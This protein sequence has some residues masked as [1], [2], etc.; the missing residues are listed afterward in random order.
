MPLFVEPF[1]KLD[2]LLGEAPPRFLIDR[3]SGLVRLLVTLVRLFPKLAGSI[4][5]INRNA[6]K[7]VWLLNVAT[8][9]RYMD[10][11]SDERLDGRSRYRVKIE[12]PRLSQ[13]EPELLL[14]CLL[15]IGRAAA[16]HSSQPSAHYR[17]A[18]QSTEPSS[19]T[20]VVYLVDDLDG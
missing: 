15:G 12:R 19:D 16:N 18:T 7:S 9:S 14:F 11:R 20:N 4:F 1:R 3:I 13:V 8:F 5:V 17:R 2:K 6:T 10:S